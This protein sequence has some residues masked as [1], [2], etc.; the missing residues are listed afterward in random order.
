[1]SREKQKLECEMAEM[2]EII[3]KA[4][5][6]YANDITDHTENEYI[7]EGLLNANYR[8]QSEGEWQK[9]YENAK[10]EVARE[11]FAEIEL[12]LSANMSSEFKDNGN[13]ALWFDYYDSH[14]AEDI[15]ELKNK[16]TEA[17]DEG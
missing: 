7:R 12:K 10:A 17:K 9:R 4:R 6:I 2:L 3:E 15:A 14:L 11:I 16:Y 13:N 1:M 8:K 5:E